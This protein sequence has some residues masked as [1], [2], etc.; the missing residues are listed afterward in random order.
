MKPNLGC[1]L[2]GLLCVSWGS[3]APNLLCHGAS[4]SVVESLGVA[5]TG[6]QDLFPKDFQPCLHSF[7]ILQV[8]SDPMF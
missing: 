7:N 6:P 8:A 3:T 2:A 1:S 4:F 5:D